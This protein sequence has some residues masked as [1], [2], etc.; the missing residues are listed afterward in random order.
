MKTIF[1]LPILLLASVVARAQT[2]STCDVAITGLRNDDGQV[3]V[4]LFAGA[5]G[6]PENLDR[7]YMGRRVAIENQTASLS[8]ELPT[9]S[10]AITFHH[11]ENKSDEMEYSWIGMPNEGFGFS[12]D[13]KVRLKA[14]S[15]EECRFVVQPDGCQLTMKAMYY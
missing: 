1:T 7:A 6:F 4:F 10:Y 12:N 2:T 13:P 11:D 15:F 5:E 9:G 8:L 14:P 3:R